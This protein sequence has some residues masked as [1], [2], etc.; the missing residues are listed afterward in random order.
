MWVCGSL[1]VCT[2]SLIPGM[3]VDVA[4]YVCVG[5]VVCVAIYYSLWVPVCV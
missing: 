5:L 1:G 3:L 4:V 2:F